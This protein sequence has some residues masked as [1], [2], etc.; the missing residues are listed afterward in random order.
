MPTDLGFSGGSGG[1]AGGGS[2][3][4]ATAG[5]VGFGALPASGTELS[6]VIRAHELTA[7]ATQTTMFPRPS[8]NIAEVCHSRN[9]YQ[10]VSPLNTTA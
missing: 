5:L 8:M 9:D 2:L 6:T 10:A 3:G 1:R 4:L 7:N